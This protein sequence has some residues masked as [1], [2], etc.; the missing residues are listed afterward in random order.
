[1]NSSRTRFRLFSLLLLP[2]ALLASFPAVADEAPIMAPELQPFVDDHSLSGA[3][4][5]VADKDKILDLEAVGYSNV[6]KQEPMKTDSVFWLASMSKSFACTLLMMLVDDGKLSVDDPVEKYLPEFKG[7]QVAEGPTAP[8]LQQVPG[9]IQGYWIKDEKG[10]NAPAQVRPPTHPLLI[11]NLLTHT[12]GMSNIKSPRQITDKDLVP[13]SEVVSFYATLPLKFDPGSKYEYSNHGMD[14]V[15]RIVEVVSGMPYGQFMKQR[16]LDPLGMKE[17]S[18][19]P[20]DEEASRLVT[21][22][23]ASD[24]A[25]GLQTEAK[26]IGFF[27]WPLSNP[28]R[29]EWPAGGLFSTAT[30]ISIF[31]RMLLNGGT[32]EGHQYLSLASMQQMTTTETGDMLN[33]G[34]NEDGYGFGW[35]TS[36]KL[37][38]GET[39]L[40]GT[41]GHGGA[42]GTEM[43]IEPKPG[44]VS[45]LMVQYEGGLFG[46]W[47]KKITTAYKKAVNDAWT[48]RHTATAAATP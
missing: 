19:W 23:E 24:A 13:L 34:L 45:V 26:P 39:G 44:R 9:A 18:F 31:C 25:K 36:K 17:T 6:A 11:R 40:P 33:K 29:Q 43:L 37:K 35:Q 38:P 47:G 42:Y 12:S 1:M 5:L 32:Y 46:P 16:L 30:D 2:T 48:Q 21:A 4:V 14:T 8:P 3:V 28:K 7:I 27:T 22:Y 10:N 20:S 15:G 41:F